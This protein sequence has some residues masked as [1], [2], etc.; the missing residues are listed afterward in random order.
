MDLLQ[1]VSSLAKLPQLGLPPFG[2]DPSAGR[3]R[4]GD[5][6]VL[7]LLQSAHKQSGLRAAPP[8][9]QQLCVDTLPA[10]NAFELA[11]EG[12]EALLA[13]FSLIGA[14]N[15]YFEA[16]P[17][18]LRSEVLRAPAK[19]PG[20]VGRQQPKLPPFDIDPSHNDMGMRMVRVVMVDRSP[21]DGSS[22]VAVD[23]CH[24]SADIVSEV[25]METVLGGDNEPKLVSLIEARLLEPLAGHRPLR[26][27]EQARR[28]VLF[29]TLTLDVPQVSTGR[30]GAVAR[31]ALH[32]RFDD[33]AP[34]VMP[35]R[36]TLGGAGS[37]TR[38]SAPKPRP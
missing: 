12:R 1:D 24:E 15:L 21:L 27:V 13:H 8:G 4:L 16:W 9:R 20:D 22:E 14:P 29:D 3:L 33:H 38:V 2:Q 30:L 28:A 11:V 6:K 23:A 25:Q 18:N 31:E 7:E 19:A 34:S 35:W 26:A 32:M 10:R 17:Q 5:P 37:L 36:K